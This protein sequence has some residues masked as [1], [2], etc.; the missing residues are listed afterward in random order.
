M[1]IIWYNTKG[2]APGFLRYTIILF[3]SCFSIQLNGHER[4]NGHIPNLSPPIPNLLPPI[5]DQLPPVPNLVPPIPDLPLIPEVLSPSGAPEI[6]PKDTVKMKIEC[7]NLLGVPVLPEG[8]IF[9]RLKSPCC[10]FIEG[11]VDIEAAVCICSALSFNNTDP[12]ID[13]PVSMVLLL[14]YC[15]KDHPPDFVCE[16]S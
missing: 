11:L 13:V 1:D 3:F 6:C 4:D 16:S 5:Q 15:R 7:A 10:K 9:N 8:A 14:N 2:F 12:K